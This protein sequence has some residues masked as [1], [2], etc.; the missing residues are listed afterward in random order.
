MNYGGKKQDEVLKFKYI[1]K[2]CIIYYNTIN[3]IDNIFF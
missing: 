2:I 1:H 3:Y